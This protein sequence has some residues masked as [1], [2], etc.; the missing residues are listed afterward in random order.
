MDKPGYLFYFVG[1]K[2]ADQMPADIL[3]QQGFLF[4]N[5]LYPVLSE[6]PATRAIGFQNPFR[7]EGFAHRK[8]PGTGTG[9]FFFYETDIFCNLVRHT[10]GIR[11][12]KAG[13]ATESKAGGVK[14]ASPPT[15][16]GSSRDTSRFKFLIPYLTLQSKQPY[17]MIRKIFLLLVCWLSFK[18]ASFAQLTFSASG[19]PQPG[20]VHTYVEGSAVLFPN[21]LQGNSWNFS[22]TPFF[23]ND[24]VIMTYKA[25]SSVPELQ[26]Y[27]QANMVKEL[28]I[29]LNNPG[30]PSE[31]DTLLYFYRY[32]NNGLYLQ[33]TCRPGEQPPFPFSGETIEFP[34]PLAMGTNITLKDTNDVF[35]MG[36]TDSTWQRSYVSRNY[37]V[38]ATGNLTLAGNTHQV[39]A[40]KH[41]Y[42][43]QDSVF[44]FNQTSN[45]WNFGFEGSNSTDYQYFLS[46][47]LGTYVLKGNFYNSEGPDDWAIAYIL[48]S[49]GTTSAGK[50]VGQDFVVY[51]NPASK[52][53]R[54]KGGPEGKFSCRISD[55]TG[56]LVREAEVNSLFVEVDDLPPGEYQ[57][58][59]ASG[60]GNISFT[61]RILISR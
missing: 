21:P 17:P 25:T 31:R 30:F 24:T 53:I 8:K 43:S 22:T 46:P 42:S 11:R 32:D 37:Q 58:Q 41:T 59:V 51:P 40:L 16:P 33:G 44:Y 6:I 45:I 57:I 23:A 54:I 47:A 60:D 28:I 9:Q 55:A 2:M 1:L 12:K 29:A 4:Q 27:P 10:S 56:R 48:N 52:S 34:L 35:Y 38:L 5:F 20:I 7:R 61:R 3:R 15:L 13:L 39:L 36:S 14:V 49:P 50:T 19:L 26:Y 18:P